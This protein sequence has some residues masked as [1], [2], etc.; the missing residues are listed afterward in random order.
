LILTAVLVI[1]FI[2][3]RTNKASKEMTGHPTR[4]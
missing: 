3:T 1:V 4:L 2:A